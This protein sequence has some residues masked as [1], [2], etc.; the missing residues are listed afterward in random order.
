[1]S[2]CPTRLPGPLR[3]RLPKRSNTWA[4]NSW[5]SNWVVRESVCVACPSDAPGLG[6]GAANHG[7]GADYKGIVPFLSEEADSQVGTN[8][9]SIWGMEYMSK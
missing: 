2:F 1:M 4:S 7:L 3:G 8:R 6:A 5:S 9:I